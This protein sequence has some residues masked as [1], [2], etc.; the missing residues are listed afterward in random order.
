MQVPNIIS[1][2]LREGDRRWDALFS[3]E[4]HVYT[5]RPSRRKRQSRSMRVRMRGPRSRALSN[6]ASAPARLPCA[7]MRA[8]VLPACL[9]RAG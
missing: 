6:T 5:A 8:A 2:D 9:C 1:L 7:R 4:P 3:K